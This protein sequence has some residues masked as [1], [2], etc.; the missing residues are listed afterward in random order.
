[1]LMQTQVY[2]YWVISVLGIPGDKN[3]NN[4]YLY[5]KSVVKEL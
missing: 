4:T 3:M 2:K 1:M 5:Y